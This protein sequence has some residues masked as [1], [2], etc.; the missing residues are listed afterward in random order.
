MPKVI[1]VVG[2]GGVGKTIIAGLTVRYLKERDFTPV[3]AVDADPSMNLDITLGVDIQQT[4]GE[5]RENARPERGKRPSYMSLTDFL[6]T[7]INLALTESNSFDLL[8]MGRPEGKGC[9]CS[10]NTNLREALKR[11]SSNYRYV[12]IDNEAGIEHISR[13]TDGSVDVMLIISDPSPKGLISAIRTKELIRTLENEVS[14]IFLIIN[15]I[16][17]KIPAK[18]IE[19]I[20][21]QGLILAGS[22]HTDPFLYE[23]ELLGKSVFELPADSLIYQDLK[24]ILGRINEDCHLW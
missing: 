21:E 8:V 12:V 6:N 10:A 15:R 22:I 23:Y 1:A 18:F 20:N 17:D 3:L 16:Q 7:Q 14:N 4:V 11:L 13:Q 2:K 19:E 24:N 9:Y 5:I